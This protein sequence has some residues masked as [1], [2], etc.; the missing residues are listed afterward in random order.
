MSNYNCYEEQKIEM[1]YKNCL[2]IV[3]IDD[4]TNVIKSLV[5]EIEN[6]PSAQKQQQGD[7]V[8]HIEM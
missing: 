1:P 2:Q 3:N 7:K 6:I 4:I 8:S 5:H